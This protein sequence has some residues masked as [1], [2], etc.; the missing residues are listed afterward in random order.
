MKE[1]RVPVASVK[2]EPSIGHG[3]SRGLNLLNLVG[4]I[5]T[6]RAKCYTLPRNSRARCSK[7]SLKF[8]IE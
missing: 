3:N 6:S 4:E 2:E 7:N 1:L 8:G 5:R